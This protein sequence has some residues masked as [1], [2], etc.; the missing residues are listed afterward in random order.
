M[1]LVKKIE[2]IH[3]YFDTK[4]DDF[5]LTLY[6]GGLPNDGIF[7]GRKKP[8]HQPP[9]PPSEGRGRGRGWGDVFGFYFSFSLRGV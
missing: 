7:L 4:V 5:A 3:H 9:K 2:K 1:I 6:G 8:H